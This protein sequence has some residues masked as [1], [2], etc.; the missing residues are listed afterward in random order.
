MPS[1]PFHRSSE[2]CEETAEE[3]LSSKQT[4]KQNR[5][6]NT[7]RGHA[8]RRTSV[9]TTAR[10]HTV[11]IRFLSCRLEACLHTHAHV[12]THA[13][14]H[15]YLVLCLKTRITVS[16][17]QGSSTTGSKCAFKLGRR[18]RVHSRLHPHK[19]VNTTALSETD[20]GR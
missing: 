5:R 19:K 1:R 17:P 3:S 14:T 11:H 15:H 6:V 20:G 4:E 13:R 16:G 18:V 10:E 8:S 2:I 7:A 12:H 9:Y